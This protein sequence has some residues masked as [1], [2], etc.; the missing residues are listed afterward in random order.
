MFQPMDKD[1][2]LGSC[3]G[4]AG[5]DCNMSMDGKK[6]VCPGAQAAAMAPPPKPQQQGGSSRQ[7]QDNRFGQLDGY[8]PYMWQQ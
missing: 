4:R 6:V 1:C 8:E 5:Q 2:T 3:I 7:G